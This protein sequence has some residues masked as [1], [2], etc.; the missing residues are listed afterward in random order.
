MKIHTHI[1]VFSSFFLN[2]CFF[3]ANEKH[4]SNNKSDLD[5][6]I[7]AEKTAIKP[8]KNDLKQFFILARNVKLDP[9]LAQLEAIF[10]G[11]LILHNNCL[12]ILVRN[13]RPTIHT[14]VIPGQY[15]VFFDNNNKI[16]G[17][18]NIK[19]KEVYSLG[20]TLHFLGIAFDDE[21]MKLSE[22]LPSYCAPRLALPGGIEKL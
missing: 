9:N 13:D 19:S 16:I 2:G 7:S 3:N 8:L 21:K 5:R 15:E 14:L 12:S 17:L 11:N 6:S 20:E 1:L 4:S 10:Q 22:N 18:K